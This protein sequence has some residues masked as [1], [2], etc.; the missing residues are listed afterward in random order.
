MK[1]N[2]NNNDI[3][4][5]FNDFIKEINTTIN[6]DTIEIETHE[7]KYLDEYNKKIKEYLINSQNDIKR[8]IVSYFRDFVYHIDFLHYNK[9][10]IIHIIK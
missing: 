3:R 6:M 2:K 8:K 9:I 5:N 1:G 7:K 4:A 10:Y